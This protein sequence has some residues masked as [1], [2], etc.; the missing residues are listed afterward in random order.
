MEHILRIFDFNVYNAKG[1]SESSDEEQNTYKDTNNFVIQLFGVD[2]RGKTYS[3]TAE[4]YKPFFYIMV[5]DTWTI[6]M[7]EDFVVH[8]KEKMGKF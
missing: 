2:E 3:V 6:K 5:N 1:E 8:L 7:K 4:G